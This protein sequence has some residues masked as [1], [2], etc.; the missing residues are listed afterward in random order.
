MGSELHFIFY[1]THLNHRL[2]K[3]SFV[4]CTIIYMSIKTNKSARCTENE[5]VKEKAA[6]HLTESNKR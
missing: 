4:L 1:C 2:F 6:S 5:K 3:L